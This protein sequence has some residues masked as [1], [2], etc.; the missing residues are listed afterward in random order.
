M[1]PGTPEPGPVRPERNPYLIEPSAAFMNPLARRITYITGTQSGKSF[2]QENVIGHTLDDDPCP[3]L[4]YAPTESNINKKVEPLIE[5]MIQQSESLNNKYS[6]RNSTQHVKRVGGGVLYL[7]WMGSTTETASTSARLVIVDELDRCSKNSEG[8]VVELVE[9]RGDAYADSR[10]AFTAT[11]THGRV[12]KKKHTET[13]FWHWQPQS[14]EHLNSPTW[15][16][17]Q[18]GTRHEWAVPCPHCHEYFVPWSE[19]LSWPGKDS[20]KECSPSEA[21]REAWLI[22]PNHG[23]VIEDKYRQSMNKAGAYVT[24]GQSVDADGTVAGESETEP[25]SHFS[26]WSSGLFSFSA[27]KTFGFLAKKLL[28]AKLSGDPDDLLSV[29]NTGFG[30]CFAVVGERPDWEAVKGCAWRY[31]TKQIIGQPEFILMTVDVQKR[32]LVYSIRAWYLGM[33]SALVESGEIFGD[34]DRGEV[35]QKLGDFYECDF[36]GYTVDEIGVDGGYRDDMVYQFVR[37]HKG[38]A[39]VMRGDILDRPFRMQKVDVD[40]RGKV[41]KYGDRRWDFDTHRAK[42][43]V[44]SRIGRDK[45][46]SGFWVVPADVEDGYCKEIVGEEFD[47]QTGKWKQLGENHWLDCETMSYML[48]RMRGLD[49]RPGETLLADTEKTKEAV[50]TTAPKKQSSK[51]VSQP[52]QQ[53]SREEDDFLGGIGDW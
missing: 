39:R 4:Y 35:W 1:P 11:P 33:G 22:C 50:I 44:H 27:K 23:C 17:W 25:N 9:A 29:Y 5:A 13:G 43:W 45:K 53:A 3:I 38:R 18:S 52:K 48:A 20:E 14:N 26:Y 32:R 37:D 12:E 21:E 15:R 49:R 42:A 6:A 28:N 30:E 10:T 46:R 24:P 34:T 47:E 2:L 31:H 40:S 51:P 41:R 36:D 7:S 16:Q 19:L 8:S